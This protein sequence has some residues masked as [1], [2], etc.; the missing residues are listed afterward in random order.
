MYQ[1]DVLIEK[2][3]VITPDALYFLH[4]DELVSLH[5]VL[6]RRI[7]FVITVTVITY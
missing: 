3:H 4:I 2:F 1:C 7:V 5:E 6:H